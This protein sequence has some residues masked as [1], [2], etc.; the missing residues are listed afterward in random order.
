MDVWAARRKRWDEHKN[1]VRR[2]EKPC[3]RCADTFRTPPGTKCKTCGRYKPI[4]RRVDDSP[5]RI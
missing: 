3:D 1:A 4:A 2:G 5:N